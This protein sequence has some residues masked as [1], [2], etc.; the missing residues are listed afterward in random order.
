MC[1]CVCLDQHLQPPC[2]A[3]AA[4][5]QGVSGAHLV[6]PLSLSQ[7]PHQVL[8]RTKRS[9]ECASQFFFFGCASTS[10][11]DAV[12]LS[13]LGLTDIFASHPN[14]APVRDELTDAP[15]VVIAG[16]IPADLDG[17]FVRYGDEI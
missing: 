10:F 15:C 7:A 12:R 3:G 13:A 2:H 8:P 6:P 16:S 5:A 4:T 17:I 9:K 14:F 11:T 1:V